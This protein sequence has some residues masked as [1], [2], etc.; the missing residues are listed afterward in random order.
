M[1]GP[2]VE[3]ALRSR[4]KGRARWRLLAKR[5]ASEVETLYDLRERAFQFGLMVVEFVESLPPGIVSQEVG[6]QLVKSGSQ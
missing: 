1:H 6:R 4:G 5:L 2:E 3:K